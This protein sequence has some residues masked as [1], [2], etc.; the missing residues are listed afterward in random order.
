MVEMTVVVVA[1][2]EKFGLHNCCYQ[3]YD[4]FERVIRGKLK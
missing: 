4:F 3:K 1:T 2:G